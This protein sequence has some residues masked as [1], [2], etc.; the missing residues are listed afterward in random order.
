MA[1]PS[2]AS[3]A[4]RRAADDRVW[5][6][7]LHVDG[8]LIQ[9]SNLFLVAQ[10]LQVV[11]YATVFSAHAEHHLVA[12]QVL[13]YFGLTLTLA[14]LYSVHRHYRYRQRVMAIA[15]QRLPEYEALESSRD[16]GPSHLPLLAYALPILGG[17]M[18]ITLLTLP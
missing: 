3:E 2:D 8:A 9:R 13:G 15:R 17:T 10:S 6:H 4:D 5:Q 16:R 18:W 11:G 7:V 12:A 1:N 14:W